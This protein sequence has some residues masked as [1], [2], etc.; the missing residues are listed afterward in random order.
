MKKAFFLIVS[1][2]VVFSVTAFSQN[3]PLPIDKEVITGTLDNGVKYYIKKNQKPEKRAELRLFV[4][5]GS[6]L[7]N[8]DQRGLG[9]FCRTHGI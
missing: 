6:V 3:Q 8:E 7:E 4:N 2:L 1:F 5:A 9:T